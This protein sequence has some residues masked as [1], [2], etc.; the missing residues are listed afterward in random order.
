[1]SPPL[2][3][4]V[5]FGFVGFG[6]LLAV[7]LYVRK[8]LSGS[9]ATGVVTERKV[10]VSTTGR[11]QSRTIHVSVVVK[12]EVEGRPHE[13]ETSLGSGVAPGYSVG[14]TVT[15]KYFPRAP[16]RGVIWTVKEIPR[17]LLMVVAVGFFWTFSYF[18]AAIHFQG[19]AGAADVSNDPPAVIDPQQ[20]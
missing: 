9:S 17:R 2:I 16:E 14:E 12:Y 20:D 4:S 18:L 5:L 15:I 19:A 3:A 11:E 8:G 10:G 1:M 6:F 7:A 13:I